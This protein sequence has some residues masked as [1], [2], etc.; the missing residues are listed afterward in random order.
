LR[1]TEDREVRT[2][3]LTEIALDAR[4]RLDY[5]RIVVALHVELSRHLENTARTELHAELAALAAIDDEVDLALGYLDFVDVKWNSPV[6]HGRFLSQAT[7]GETAYKEATAPA[8]V[9]R[10]ARSQTV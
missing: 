8:V 9:V 6:F 3:H 2:D 10:Y 1:Q 4:L 5:F 7:A